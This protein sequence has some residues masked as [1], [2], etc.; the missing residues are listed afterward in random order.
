MK[1][2]KPALRDMAAVGMGDAKPRLPNN[3]VR[4]L[5]R[6]KMH[7]KA[8]RVV[9]NFYVGEA[10]L[11]ALIGR[12]NFSDAM[13]DELLD[14]WFEA[15]KGYLGFLWAEPHRHGDAVHEG[16]GCEIP[17]LDI[18]TLSSEHSDYLA[19]SERMRNDAKES[20]LPIFPGINE[21]ELD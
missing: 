17:I 8:K 3:P 1:M 13:V 19:G 20:G 2:T 11:L 14:I 7:P 9:L 16:L 4:S 21:L 15:E 10:A 18:E 12:H 6:V 5:L